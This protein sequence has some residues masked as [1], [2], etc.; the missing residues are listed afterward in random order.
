MT[1]L[2]ALGVCVLLGVCLLL[3]ACGLDVMSPDARSALVPPT[4]AEDPGLPQMKVT[5]AGRERTLHLRSFGDPSDPVAFVLPGGPGADHRLLLPLRALSDRYRVVMWD[6]RGAGLSERAP[7][8]ELTLDAF[9][10]EIAAVR[11]AVAP[12]RRVTLIGHSLG[13]G[14]MLRFT[15][16]NPDVVE[17]L[18][19]IEPG[20]LTPEGRGSYDGG[21]VSFAHGQDHFWQNEILTSQDHAASDYKAVALLPEA[22]RSFTCTGDPPVENPMWR[23]GA[24][25]YHVVLQDIRR[26]HADLQWAEGIGGF[27][28]DVLLIAGTCGAAGVDFQTRYNLEA[29]P[30]AELVTIPGA[31]HL[32]LFTTHAEETL[33]VLRGHLAA[34]GAALANEAGRPPP[35]SAP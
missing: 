31:G 10:E 26:E 18:V 3:T 32:S 11:A 14:V 25:Q 9:G 34:Y 19:L 28:R 21:A 8:G 5:V 17:E 16:A 20:P 4:A 23:F 7:A 24:L 1:H 6:P 27:D 30:Q 33:E 35:S 22:L 2:R 15:A 29:L 13:A 12:G